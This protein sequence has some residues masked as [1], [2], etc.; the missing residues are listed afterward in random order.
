LPELAERINE[1]FRDRKVGISVPSMRVD[2]MLA[3]IPW[4]VN[5]V[6]KSGLTMAVEAAEDDMRAA[7]KKLVTDGDLLA[8]VRQAYS[9]GWNSLKLYFMVGFPG[10]RPKDIDGIH[11]L[12]VEV[13]EAARAVKGRPAQVNASVGWLVPKPHTPFQWAAQPRAAYFHE[14]RMRL[15]SLERSKRSAVR[16]KL[17]NVERSVLECVFS[18]GDRRLGATIEA[19]WRAG[20]R[21]D[22]W[23]ECFS[24]DV[25]RRAFD[26]TGI[27][28]DFYAHREKS[29][30]EIL[31]WSHLRSGNADPYLRQHYDDAF[32]QIGAPQP[33]AV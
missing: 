33:V 29:P 8:A 1:R 28:P 27:D 19:A 16:I 26:A 23:D 12:S 7:I 9:A 2:K 22:G 31:A 32:V 25:W 18:V 24:A 30:D 15:R 13:S 4:M 3:H 21:F 11:R 17:H 5:Q 14:A 10:E 6:R 20:A